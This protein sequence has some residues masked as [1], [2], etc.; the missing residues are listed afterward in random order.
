MSLT[1]VV[2]SNSELSSTF[3]ANEKMIFINGRENVDSIYAVV[4]TKQ[5]TRD[6]FDIIKGLIPNYEYFRTVYSGTY[7]FRTS[8]FLIIVAG[9]S[10][11]HFSER[12][13]GNII[14]HVY[15]HSDAVANVLTSITGSIEKDDSIFCSWK[16][17]VGNNLKT[18]MI[19]IQNSVIH[20]E[21]YPYIEDGC[22][23]FFSSYVDDSASIL[24]LYGPPG[25]GK[26]SFLRNF[27]HT[28]RRRVVLTYD[29]SLIESDDFM[30]D[31]MVGSDYDTLI[32]E[33]ADNLLMSR[34]SG[35]MVMDK[36]L[37]M[38]DG[39]IKLPNKKII[40]TTN[41]SQVAKIDAA[42]LRPGRCF[43]AIEFRSLTPAE[44]ER[45]ALAADLPEKDWF[46][47]SAWTL[48]EVFQ[49]RAHVPNNV[50][51]V[52]FGFAS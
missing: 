16:Y 3:M 50:T 41:L 17:P 15:G 30:A 1:N 36:F 46:T 6:V 21:F 14:I 5:T 22:D 26:T 9:S 13:T 40:F 51:R 31:F 48:G 39:L 2:F 45:A 24:I 10:F 20:D 4:R 29:K 44:A 37:N 42:L 19:N 52:A 28:K 47:Q 18:A 35:N 33:D 8:D 11:E 32:I 12:N 7:V 23:R 27:I 34:E 25:T 43:G 49:K 38:G